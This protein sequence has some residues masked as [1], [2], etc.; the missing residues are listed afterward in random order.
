VLVQKEKELNE[1][2]G[3]INDPDYLDSLS[4]QAEAELK[5]KQR[6]MGQE[7]GQQQ[8][9]LYQ[10]LSQANFKIVQRLT[11]EVAKAADKVASQKNLSMVVNEDA[12]FF[13][14]KKLD[15]TED[16]IREMDT[17]FENSK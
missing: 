7:L 4:P 1:I 10:T 2:S 3:K 11:E 14:A 16:V 6:Q 9:Q 5:H 17:T 12:C 15:I 8:Q 13:Y